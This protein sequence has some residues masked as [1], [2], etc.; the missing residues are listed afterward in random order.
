[1]VARLGTVLAV[2]AGLGRLACAGV[3][4]APPV[5]LN[6]DAV[7]V[8]G[9]RRWRPR[10]SIFATA[11]W[12]EDRLT[13]A[14]WL[15]YRLTPGW[16]V[17]T[18]A[19]LHPGLTPSQFENLNRRMHEHSLRTATAVALAMLGHRVVFDADGLLVLAVRRDHPASGVVAPGD[20]LVAAN[21]RRLRRPEDLGAVVA[22]GGRVA[23]DVR[24]ADPEGT[25]PVAATVRLT[26]FGDR[27][28]GASRSRRRPAPASLGAARR[29][30]G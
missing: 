30:G 18:H 21:G 11:M 7:V 8:R 25:A 5:A 15:R 10:P 13:P 27:V 28:L 3:R 19:E 14:E 6:G 9:A 2:S 26:P 29:R 24:Y 12:V 16:E 23:L 4:S 1:M 20:V 17:R 22:A